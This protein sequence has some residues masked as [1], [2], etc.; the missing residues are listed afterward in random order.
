MRSLQ[1]LVLILFFCFPAAAA[2]KNWPEEARVYLE[3]LPE[4]QLTLDYVVA[5]A[6][7]DA[8]VFKLHKTDYLKGEALYMNSVSAEDFKLKGSYFYIDNK[9]EP[10]SPFMPQSTKGWEA[11]V[12]FEQYLATGTALN[13]EAFNSPKKLSFQTIPD[14]EYNETKLSFG[15][16]QS[17]LGDF[18]GSGYRNLKRSAKNSRD[19]LELSAIVQIEN[20]TIDTIKLYYQAWLKQQTVKNLES[21]LKRRNRLNN[22]LKSQARRGMVESSDSLQVEGAALNNEA[23]FIN[24]KQDLQSLWEQLVIQLKMPKSFLEVPADEIPI[25]LDAPENESLKYCESLKFDDILANS[26]SVKQLMKAV[27]S[28]KY[29]YDALKQKLMPDVR[30]QANYVANAIDGSARQTWRDAGNQENP[31]L[32]AGVSVSFPLQNRQQKSQL[33]N[34]HIEYE[35]AKTNRDISVNNMEVQWRLLCS[36]LKRKIQNRDLYKIVNQKNKKRVELDNRRFELGRIKAFQWVQSEDDEAQAFLR[37]QQTEVDVRVLA[38]DVQKQTGHL[39]DRA[40]GLLQI[41]SSHE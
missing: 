5:R 10:F 30:L 32:T 37:F 36:N 17:L 39:L 41:K 31:A 7:T 12:G 35:Q 2:V 6:I 9:N 26:N 22:I 28:A 34:A 4:K 23:D 14:I 11:K 40:A 19:A 33:L 16:D 29:K 20:S 21:S 3:Q 15:L 25:I 24:N 8:D 13:V 27:D 1:V 18:L 38:W